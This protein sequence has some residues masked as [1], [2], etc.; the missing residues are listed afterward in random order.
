MLTSFNAYNN[1]GL[2]TTQLYNEVVVYNHK[3]HGKFQLGRR[4]FNFRMKPYFPKTLTPEFLL[5]D[6]VNNINYVAEDTKDLLERVKKKAL[7]MNQ[8]LLKRCVKAYGSVRAKNFFTFL[9]A[10]K[11]RGKH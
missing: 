1:L 4:V 7:T 11:G 2:G 10:E 8:N 6:L 5:V 9:F 3:R